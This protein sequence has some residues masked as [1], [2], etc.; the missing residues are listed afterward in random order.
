VASRF[1]ADMYGL[2]IL[3]HGIQDQRHNFTRFLVIGKKPAD[4]TGRDK[5]SIAFVSKDEPGILYKLL[6]PLAEAKINLTKIE[7]RPLK[8]KVWEYMFFMDMDGHASQKK[9]ANALEKLRRSCVSFKI[10]GS[11]PRATGSDS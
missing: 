3:A 11:Y 1:A 7:S 9:I 8:T 6:K 4:K 2:N 10:L 5:T